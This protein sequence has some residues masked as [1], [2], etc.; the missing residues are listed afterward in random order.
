[1]VM[2]YEQD[3][4]QRKTERTLIVRLKEGLKGAKTTTGMVD[5]RIFQG[6]ENV[7][8]VMDEQTCLWRLRY[9]AGILPEPLLQQFTS[10]EKLMKF[11][12]EYF[13]KRGMDIVDVKD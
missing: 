11:A 7:V 2:F 6:K 9:R 8:A 3:D 12:R 13:G 4:K 5:S 1:M 10:F